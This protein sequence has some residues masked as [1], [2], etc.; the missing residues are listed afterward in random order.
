MCSFEGFKEKARQVFR[1]FPGIRRGND[2]LFIPYRP[3]RWIWILKRKR[4]YFDTLVGIEWEWYFSQ[5]CTFL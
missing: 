2:T 5:G 1:E 4:R 3:G